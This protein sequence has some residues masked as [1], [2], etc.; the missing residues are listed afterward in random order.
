MEDEPSFLEKRMILMDSIMREDYSNFDHV[1]SQLS[2]LVQSLEED[3][4]FRALEYI[5]LVISETGSTD[6]ITNELYIGLRE[7]S[8]FIEN[9]NL[10]Y[11]IDNILMIIDVSDDEE[12]DY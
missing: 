9:D 12:E 1:I 11:L 10:S 8:E 7:V 5:R 4:L 6:F 2:D 3:Q